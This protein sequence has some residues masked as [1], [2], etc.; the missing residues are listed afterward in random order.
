LDA[1]YIRFVVLLVR[2]AAK[3]RTPLTLGRTLALYWFGRDI[4]GIDQRITGMHLGKTLR[5]PEANFDARTAT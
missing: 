4:R 1:L 5:I 2:N 3:Q